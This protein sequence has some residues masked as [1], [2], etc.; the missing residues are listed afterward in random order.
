MAIETNLE[1]AVTAL[2]ANLLKDLGNAAQGAQQTQA[3][4]AVGEVADQSQNARD[5][6][7]ASAPL[8]PNRGRNLDIKV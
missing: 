3:R 5:L 1:S 7:T 8:D 6:N 2:R 4:N